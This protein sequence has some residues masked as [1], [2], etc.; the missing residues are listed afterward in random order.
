MFIIKNIG[1]SRNKGGYEEIRSFAGGQSQLHAFIA[2]FTE[3]CASHMLVPIIHQR[4][5]ELRSD[6]DNIPAYPPFR[7]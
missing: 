5:E 6:T 2:W 1:M 3:L 4:R 7:Q